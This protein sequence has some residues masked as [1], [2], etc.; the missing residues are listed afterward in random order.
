[1]RIYLLY[2]KA[3]KPLFNYDAVGLAS[4]P[5]LILLNPQS[6]EHGFVSIRGELTS[7]VGVEN[8]RDTRALDCFLYSDDYRFCFHRVRQRSPY[9][10]ATG[11]INGCRQIKYMCPDFRGGGLSNIYW[12]DQIRNARRASLSK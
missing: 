7:L 11:P 12:L 1:M 5:I 9:N 3:A 4:F 6:F 8:S 10:L 2:F